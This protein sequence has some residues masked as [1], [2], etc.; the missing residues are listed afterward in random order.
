MP[1]VYSRCVDC[2][3]VLAALQLI[4]ITPT[5]WQHVAPCTPQRRAAEAT[6]VA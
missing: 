1:H 6:E 3:G 2:G 5:G 4:R